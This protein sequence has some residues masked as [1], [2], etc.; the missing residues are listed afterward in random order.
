[1]RTRS[2]KVLQQTAPRSEVRISAQVVQGQG[3]TENT[4]SVE[5]AAHEPEMWPGTDISRDAAERAKSIDP[6]GGRC[7][8]TGREDNV[9]PCLIMPR[10]TPEAEVFGLD[11]FLVL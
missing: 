1:M 5:G 10:N 3:D 9:R 7:L 4:P 6:N 8:I 2:G 11:W